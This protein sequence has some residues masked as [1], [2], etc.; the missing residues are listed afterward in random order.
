MDQQGL[1]QASD[2]QQQDTLTRIIT[3]PVN[4]A[5][6]KAAVYAAFEESLRTAAARV[7]CTPLVVW[8]SSES[9]RRK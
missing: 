4:F 1:L 3:P 6:E 2:G 7:E 5:A 9:A 8:A